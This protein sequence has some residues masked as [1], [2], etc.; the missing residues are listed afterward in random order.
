MRVHRPIAYLP[1]NDNGTTVLVASNADTEEA[2]VFE[3]R[4][5]LDTVLSG[6]ELNAAGSVA[7]SGSD[8]EIYFRT[9][10]MWTAHASF[11]FGRSV[12][13]AT[14]ALY[15]G[16]DYTYRSS[17]GTMEGPRLPGY[18]LLNLKLDGR[19]LGADMYL[20]VMN[21]LD[22]QYQTILGYLMTPRTIVYG[23]SWRI[24]D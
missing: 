5:R 24:F 3:D 10:P 2:G 4:I 7:R 16:L 22:S 13:Q 14:S 1:T 19:L 8:R 17:R 12:F 6:F 15:I 18:H 23:L 11:R 9:V 21:T 20:M